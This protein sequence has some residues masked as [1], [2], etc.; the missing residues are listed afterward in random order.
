MINVDFKSH[1]IY[2][3]PLDAGDST[4]FILGRKPLPYRRIIRCAGMALTRISG[5]LHIMQDIASPTFRQR[6][7]PIPAGFHCRAS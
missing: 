7:K 1:N 3:S 4:F 2:P 6:I 5:R